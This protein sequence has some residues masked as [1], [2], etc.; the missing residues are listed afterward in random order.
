MPDHSP[1]LKVSLA[2]KSLL[3]AL[4][5]TIEEIAGVELGI[6][7]IVFNAGDSGRTSYGSNCKRHEVKLAL[8][9][10]LAAWED[11]LPDVPAHEVN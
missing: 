4:D 10:L 7:L 1:E 8:E 3:G 5:K 2:M 6:V 9:E 11:G